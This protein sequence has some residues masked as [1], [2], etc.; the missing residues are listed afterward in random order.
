VEV[1][2]AQLQVDKVQASARMVL[3]DQAKKRIT[4]PLDQL[5]T[6]ANQK[7]EAIQ[8]IQKKEMEYCCLQLSHVNLFSQSQCMLKS[9]LSIRRGSSMSASATAGTTDEW[10]LILTL[11]SCGRVTDKKVSNEIQRLV[12]V[13]FDIDECS[14]DSAAIRNTETDCRN[15]DGFFGY[16]GRHLGQRIYLY[17]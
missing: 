11:E 16:R 10:S 14:A 2:K 13:C 15:T 7:E 12:F 3:S 9:K 17:V 8:A 4:D 5:S 1:A 6:K